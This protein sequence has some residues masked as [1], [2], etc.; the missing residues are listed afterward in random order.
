MDK[1]EATNEQK[2]EVIDIYK[3]IQNTS[4]KLNQSRPKSVASA[5]VFYWI[6]KTKKDISMKEFTEKVDL[7]EITVDKLSKE[8]DRIIKTKKENRIKRVKNKTNERH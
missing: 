5:L 2:Q 7:S 6:Q 1:F 4:Y 8:I 3:Q